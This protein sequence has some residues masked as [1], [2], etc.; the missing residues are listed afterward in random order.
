MLIKG[1]DIYRPKYLFIYLFIHLCGMNLVQH[2][3]RRDDFRVLEYGGELQ[4]C[5][6]V[7]NFSTS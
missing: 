3:Q 5:I 6:T 2:A 1:T 4:S 7:G